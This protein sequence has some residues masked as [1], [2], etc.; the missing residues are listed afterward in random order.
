M[1]PKAS[2]TAQPTLPELEAS[3]AT[4]AAA[5][6]VA[7]NA[8]TLQTFRDIVREVIKEENDNLRDEIKRC[9]DP[10]STGL[11]ECREKLGEHENELNNQD[12]RL[13]TMEAS[14]TELH[15]KYDKLLLKVDDLENRSRRCNLLILHQARGLFLLVWSPLTSG[16]RK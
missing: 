11:I 2:K 6:K 13:V 14:Y 1:P 10:I 12:A 15:N 9:I 3:R 4:A 7:I 5:N 8:S 16:E